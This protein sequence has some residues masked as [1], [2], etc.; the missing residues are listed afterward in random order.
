[1]IFCEDFRNINKGHRPLVHKLLESFVTSHSLCNRL[2]VR[3]A[4]L[5]RSALKL[6]IAHRLHIYKCTYCAEIF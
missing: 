5:I 6:T 4:W 1:M 3:A 2:T